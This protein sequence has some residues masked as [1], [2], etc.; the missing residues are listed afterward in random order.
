MSYDAEPSPP[1]PSPQHNT[2][3]IRQLTV[4]PPQPLAVSPQKPIVPVNLLA[5][6]HDT[7]RA[8]EIS[9]RTLWGLTKRGEIPCVRI[10][11]TVRYDPKDLADFIARKKRG[12]Q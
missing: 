12:G 1:F 9:E 8:L 7:A 5:K 4:S 3:A 2:Q 10:G 6:V 11:R